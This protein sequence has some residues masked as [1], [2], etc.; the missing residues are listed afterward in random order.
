MFRIFEQQSIEYPKQM[1]GFCRQHIWELHSKLALLLKMWK[2]SRRN[3]GRWT[4]PN[5]CISFRTLYWQRHNFWILNSH[6]DACCWWCDWEQD[7]WW[8]SHNFDKPSNHRH[9]FQPDNQQSTVRNIKDHQLH[10]SK[11]KMICQLDRQSSV[12]WTAYRFVVIFTACALLVAL[13]F[14]I[15]TCCW[16]SVSFVVSITNDSFTFSVVCCVVRW[17]DSSKVQVRTRQE[18]ANCEKSGKHRSDHAEFYCSR[19]AELQL[20]D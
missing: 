12:H 3:T 17:S 2:T 20:L 13:T 19:T 18:E 15:M 5:N 10:R 9:F 4:S 1:N 11:K 8:C 7:C 16:Q 6:A 14:K